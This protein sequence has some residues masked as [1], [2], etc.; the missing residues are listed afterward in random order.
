MGSARRKAMNLVARRLVK[1]VA[2]HQSVERINASR[3]RIL[4]AVAAIFEEAPT[5]V[6]DAEQILSGIG[7]A[8]RAG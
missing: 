5:F 2:R 3:K 7:A 6:R 1:P 4:R 8:Q